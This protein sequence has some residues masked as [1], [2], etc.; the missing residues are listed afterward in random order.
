MRWI[1]PTNA[2]GSIAVKPPHPQPRAARGPVAGAR[3][4]RRERLERVE[5]VG[6]GVFATEVSVAHTAWH[7]ELLLLGY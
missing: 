2:H 5:P 7:E 4:P 6:R 1:V 3:S